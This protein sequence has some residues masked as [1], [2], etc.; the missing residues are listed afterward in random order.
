MIAVLTERRSM[1]I[2]PAACCAFV[3]LSCLA[4]AD[5]FKTINGKEYKDVTVKRVE[6]DGI[7]VINQKRG[8]IAKLYFTELSKEVQERFGYEPQKAAE[9]QPQ[10]DLA[11]KSASPLVRPSG[12]A[13][14]NK[15]K[16]SRI[17]EEIR[18][19]RSPLELNRRIV[20]Q[21]SGAKWPAEERI[22]IL[23][24]QIQKRQN[25]LQRLGASEQ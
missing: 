1:K 22:L 21:G 7:T 11:K 14:Q 5:N 13:R 12:E 19:L 24:Q 9:K 20:A 6:P 18:G 8:I 4:F 10:Q 16:I 3:C 23:E 2:T 15:K 17:R 25:E